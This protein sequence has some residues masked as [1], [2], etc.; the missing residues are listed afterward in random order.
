V[1]ILEALKE[2]TTS[3]KE[4]VDNK[5]VDKI[6]G[7][8]LSTND[9]TAADKKKVAS[10]PNDL[11]I[12]EDKLYLAQDGVPI[13]DSAVTLSVNGVT[14]ADDISYSNESVTGATNVKEALDVLASS[15]KTQSQIIVTDDGAGNVVLSS[16]KSQ[17]F[18]TDDGVGNVILIMEVPN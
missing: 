9:Y 7:K 6:D 4:W 13:A 18:T 10:I 5:K 1:N 15:I 12:D 14:E 3:I 11:V 2:V 8:G 16:I 17:L